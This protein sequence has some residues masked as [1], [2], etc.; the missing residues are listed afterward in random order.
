MTGNATVHVAID[1]PR[2]RGTVLLP[3]FRFPRWSLRSWICKVV[4][5]DSPLKHEPLISLA[6]ESTLS[7]TS[8]QSNFCCAH[9]CHY[10]GERINAIACR[11]VY[12][13][14]ARAKCACSN[15]MD[16]VK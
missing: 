3:R 8:T 9:A 14:L 6:G 5:S 15:V 4:E 11:A 16:E 10:H 2:I 1:S 12:V 7:V 13:D